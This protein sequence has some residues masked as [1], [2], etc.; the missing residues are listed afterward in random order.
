[1]KVSQLIMTAVVSIF[2]T[3]SIHAQSENID[4]RMLVKI[5]KQ[6]DEAI[7]IRLANLEKARTEVSITDLDGKVWFSEYV[8]GEHGYSKMLNLSTLTVGTYTVL[9]KNKKRT[10]LQAMEKKADGVYF[11]EAGATN[12]TQLTSSNANTVARVKGRKTHSFVVQLAN[13][14][15]QKATVQLYHINGIVMFKDNIQ[16]RNGY[17]KEINLEGLESGV[18]ALAVHTPQLQFVQWITITNDTIRVSERQT[19]NTKDE[20]SRV[21]IR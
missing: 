10:D 18:Y 4:H 16:S 2:F 9:V 11:Y 13:L 15:Q 17:A 6:S 1:M 20:R 7:H 12:T 19:L 14:R 8:W 3:L 5:E 21:A